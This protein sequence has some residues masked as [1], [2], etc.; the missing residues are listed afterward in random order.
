MGVDGGSCF[1]CY[2]TFLVFFGTEMRAGA[3]DILRFFRDTLY[4]TFVYFPVAVER[5]GTDA[6]GNYIDGYHV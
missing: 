4:A 6:V 1:Y 5:E 3:V 2:G